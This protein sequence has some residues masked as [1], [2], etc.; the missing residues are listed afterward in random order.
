MNPFR[1][2]SF[3]SLKASFALLILLL[4]I[5]PVSSVGIYPSSIE[6]TYYNDL[7]SSSFFIRNDDELDYDVSVSIGGELAHLIE[8]DDSLS[9]VKAKS[10]EEVGFEL[11]LRNTILPPGRHEA[12]FSFTFVPSGKEGQIK[13]F[14]VVIAKAFVEV[15]YP[16]EFVELSIIGSSS[17]I[18]NAIKIDV[19]LSNKG[20]KEIEEIICEAS[21]VDASGNTIT[22]SNSLE[23]VPA[24]KDEILSL[25]CEGDFPVGNYPFL[26][27]CEYA[28]KTID[29]EGSAIIEGNE[30]SVEDFRISSD[31]YSFKL[32]NLANSNFSTVYAKIHFVDDKNKTI[33]TI[34]S[35]AIS[36]NS[37]EEEIIE[38]V[39]PKDLSIDTDAV[40][41]LIE[42]FAEGK[43]M[44]KEMFLTSFS[45]DELI[46]EKEMQ[47]EDEA[48][49][50]DRRIW[51]LVGVFA[52]FLSFIISLSILLKKPEGYF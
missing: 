49:D 17:Q 48:K 28:D 19:L 42:L 10:Q 16:E 18:E 12:T 46:D 27:S 52:L 7:L 9:V 26:L 5:K 20:I 4:A 39:I 44:G 11:D 47:E 29:V 34:N 31:S 15:P 40:N 25:S 2:K 33:S 37:L 38:V 43:I 23:N 13:A 36:L 8:I 22:C 3:L 45:S 24:E 14:P 32:K 6:L 1:A 21:V 35:P 51:I 50:G 30:L 41:I